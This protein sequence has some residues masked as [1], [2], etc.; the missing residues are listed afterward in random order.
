GYRGSAPYKTVMTHGF[1]VDKDKKK[2]SKSAAK[3]AGKPIDVA[4]YYDKYG[5]D[6]VRLWVSS[7]DWQNEVPFGEDLFKQVAEPYRRLRN[8]LRILLGNLD[9]FK[10][11]GDPAHLELTLLDRWILERLHAVIA[12]CRK[13][14]ETYEFRKVFNA[15]NQFCTTDLSAIYIDATK[16][17]MYCDAADSPRR[18]AAQHAMQQIFTALAELLAPILAFTADEAWEHA[19]FT[20]GSIHE[21]D[22]PV[23]DPDFA[24]GAATHQAERLFEIKYVIQTAIEARIQAREFTRNNEADVDLTIPVA[25]AVLLPLLNDREFATEF[26]II[27]NL[28]A[29]TTDTLQATARLTDHPLCPRCRKHEP[30]RASGLCAR[31][32]RVLAR[33]P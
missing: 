6:I 26:F 29:T 22:F 11:G 20:T 9:G 18:R 17:R 19:N 10:E 4:H 16:D 28:H 31:C 3:K 30:A 7:V 5:A 15:L 33:Q 8:T 2:L 25:D 12:E 27:A 32:D 23:P 1:V 14:Y 13:A 24:P 21:Q